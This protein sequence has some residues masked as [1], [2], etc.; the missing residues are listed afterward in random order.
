MCS[1][2]FAWTDGVSFSNC[3]TFQQF[4]FGLSRNYS[5]FQYFLIFQRLSMLNPRAEGGGEGMGWGF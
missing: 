1:S 3:V 2:M 5:T 4:L